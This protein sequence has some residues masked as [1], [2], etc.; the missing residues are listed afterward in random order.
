MKVLVT[1]MPNNPA[2]CLLS[3]YD[4]EWDVFECILSYNGGAECEDCSKCP[5]L[6]SLKDY[7]P[8]HSLD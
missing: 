3:S 5:Y 2:N 4:N 7:F 8:E 1:E 6:I